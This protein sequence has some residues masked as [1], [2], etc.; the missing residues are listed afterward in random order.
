MRPRCQPTGGQVMSHP[1]RSKLPIP[2]QPF[3]GVANRTL[4]GSQPDW[5]AIGHVEAPDGAPNV[6]LV[7]IDDAG[8][9]NAE[10]FGGPDRHAEL[11]AGSRRKVCGTTASTSRRSARRPGRRSSPVA[12]ATRSASARSAS[13]RRGSPATRRSC[14]TTASPSPDPAGQRLQH[15]GLRQV[16]PD[17]GRSA[18]PRRAVRPLAGRLGLR[19]LLRVPRRRLGAVGPVPDREPEDH[20][21]SSGVLRRGEPLLPARRHGRQDDR[22]AAR[23]PG[24]GRERSRSSPT[25]RPAAATPRITWPRHVGREVRGQVRPGLGHAAR[26]DLRPAE[27]A[28]CDPG[29]RRAHAAR[30]RLPRVGRRPGQAQGVLRAPDG[31]LRRLLGERRPQRRPRARRDRRARRARRTPSSSGSGAT[32]APAW[33][34]RSPARSTS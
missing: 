33:R 23:D 30:R 10:T 5:E 14:R 3:A 15:R 8:F 1:D 7:L 17:A 13:S 28:R 26:G 31:G 24:T 29:R 18:G 25:S 11:H 2:R 6:L 22:V 20:R 12:T 16:A 21:H 4:D 32:T 19:L 27:G 34:A 9:G